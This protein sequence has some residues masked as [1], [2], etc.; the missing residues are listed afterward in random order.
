MDFFTLPFV[1]KSKTPLKEKVNLKKNAPTHVGVLLILNVSAVLFYV[2]IP[3][4]NRFTTAKVWKK[5]I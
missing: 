5:L 2:V 1:K 3:I 4:E